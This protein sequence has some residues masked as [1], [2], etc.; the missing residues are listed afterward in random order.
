MGSI[1][2]R[3]LGQVIDNVRTSLAIEIL[4]ACAGIDQRRPL[5][6]A[7]GVAAAHALVRRVV[8]EL[9]DDRPLYRDIEAVGALI[10][11]GELV[12]AVEAVVGP[13]A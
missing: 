3:K 5:V 7:K 13:L 1:S 2:A 6:P 8:P 9:V 11:S 4:T 10:R 12:R